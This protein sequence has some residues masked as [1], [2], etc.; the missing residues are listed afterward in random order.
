[1]DINKTIHGE[2]FKFRHRLSD[3]AFTRD[4]KLNFPSLVLYLLNLRKGSSQVELDQFFHHLNNQNSLTQ[5]VTKSAFFQARKQLSHHA[6]IELNSVFTRGFYE[7]CREVKTWKGFRLCAIDGSQ[8]RLPK[9]NAVTE[10]FGLHTGNEKH[11][12]CAMGLN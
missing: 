3:N 5:T 2:L 8:L 6:F 11:P 9:E 12:G 1:V 4:R 10:V 7:K